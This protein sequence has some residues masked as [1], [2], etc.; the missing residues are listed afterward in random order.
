[1]SIA[2]SCP[3]CGKTFKVP[4]DMAGKK[5]K[6]SGCGVMIQIANTVGIT[7]RPTSRSRGTASEA[8]DWQD[9][10]A[11]KKRASKPLDDDEE[12]AGEDEPIRRRR[13]KKRKK[14]KK[15][16]GKLLAFG[17]VGLAVLL[18]LGAGGGFAA[19]YFWPRNN[20]PMKF[21]PDD[22]HMIIS[23]K[24]DELEH[25]GALQEI[26]KGQGLGGFRDFQ[27]QF[28]QNS[29]LSQAVVLRIWHGAKTRAFGLGDPS[30]G[31]DYIDVIQTKNAIKLDDYLEVS[32]G[33]N[34]FTKDRVGRYTIYV[35]AK[36]TVCLA[37]SKT[38]IMATKKETL[39]T[40]LERG[41]AP[42]FSKGLQDALD[43]VNFSKPFVL[44][45]SPV[46]GPQIRAPGAPGAADPFG[47]DKAVERVDGLALN[48]DID[49]D[50]IFGFT[51]FCRNE[52]SARDFKTA[53]DKF[54][55]TL[56][57]FP[58]FPKEGMDLLTAVKLNV[59]GSTVE[60]TATIKTKTLLKLVGR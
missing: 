8:D 50:M 60:G 3:D 19:W 18:L 39:R 7:E 27:R 16:M 29:A 10:P 9:E 31:E 52:T 40:V 24:W 36:E 37:D 47:L 57:T 1:M 53:W 55:G 22:C 13:P 56:K 33:A 45:V 26:Q 5:A 30:G 17:M 38:L 48:A 58:G 43:K 25:S 2:F 34:T 23:L 21:M 28:H 12:D 15:A 44:A 11:L 42:V 54:L 32:G 4:D 6:C 41:K 59:A 51:I 49:A 14:Q 35:A 20:D 46:A